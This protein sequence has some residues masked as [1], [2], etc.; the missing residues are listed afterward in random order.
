[1]ECRLRR[2][3]LTV[4]STSA[5]RVIYD[6]DDFMNEDDDEAEEIN[7]ESSAVAKS[8]LEGVQ[9]GATLQAC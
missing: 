6:Q 8:L 3:L 1:M 2:S 9:Q 5:N 4:T 7:V